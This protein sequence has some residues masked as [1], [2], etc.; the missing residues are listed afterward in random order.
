MR[1]S[2]LSLAAFL[3]SREVDVLAELI[4][5]G[6]RVGPMLNKQRSTLLP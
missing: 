4:K 3:S 5:N 6:Q 2:E 1:S